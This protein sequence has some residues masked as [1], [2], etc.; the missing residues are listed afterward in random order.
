M[1]FL[2]PDL[3]RTAVAIAVASAIHGYG[4]FGYGYISVALFTVLSL[5]IA[6]AALVLTVVSFPVAIFLAYLDGQRNPI[7][8]RVLLAVCAGVLPAVP[9]GVL[10]LLRFGQ[11][12]VFQASFG[13]FLLLFSAYNTT[14]ARRGFRLPFWSGPIFGVLGGF[15]G[16]AIVSGG[17]PIVVFAYSQTDDPRQMKGTTQLVFVLA[18]SFRL[19]WM[20]ILQGPGSVGNVW[21]SLVVALPA[22]LLIWAGHRLSARTSVV[23]FRL[24][25]NVLLFGFGVYLIV[26][27]FT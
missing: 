15:L 5:D 13:A 4:G 17:P 26:Q 11:T 14:L 8:F 6:A 21:E 20:R 16:G 22:V 18:S 1:L 10:F 24:V 27:A 2:S 19:V 7:N 23:L 9:L 25:V 3:L 12:E